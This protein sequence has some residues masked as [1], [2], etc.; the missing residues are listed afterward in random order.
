MQEPF[1]SRRRGGTGL[2]LAIAQ[3]IVEAHGGTVAA[4][5]HPRGGGLM[6]VRLPPVA[7]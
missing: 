2:G 1:F 5:N 6:S 7:G 3:R 4:G